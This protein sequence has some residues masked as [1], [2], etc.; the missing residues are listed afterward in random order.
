MTMRRDRDRF[1]FSQSHK[2]WVTQTYLNSTPPPYELD[3]NF[4]NFFIKKGIKVQN[5]FVSTL[6]FFKMK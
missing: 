5:Y 1:C 4:D 2:I 6:W 3:L